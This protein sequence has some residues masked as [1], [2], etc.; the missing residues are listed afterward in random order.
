MNKNWRSRARKNIDKR[1]SEKSSEQD[2]QAAEVNEAQVVV[3]EP[4]MAHQN[5]AEALQPGKQSLHFPAAPIAAQRPPVLRLRLGPVLAVGSNPRNSLGAQLLIE[6]ITVVSAV[7]HK[8]LRALRSEP[9]RKCCCNQRRLMRGSPRHVHGE[10]NTCS[11]C[12]CHDLAAFPALGFPHCGPPFFAAAKVASTKHSDKSSFPRSRRSSAQA[13]SPSA[14]APLR[15]HCWKRSWQVDLGGKALGSS[16]HCAPVRSIHKMPSR[17]LRSS[18]R[19]RPRRSSRAWGWGS[20]DSTMAHW[21]SVNFIADKLNSQ[22][23]LCLDFS[24]EL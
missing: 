8:A 17:I 6:G 20:K 11:V 22:T 12:H 23:L 14:R 1:S 9:M 4:I 21:A 15:F 10:R 18:W 24:D 19:A 2:H 13:L 3:S 16:S 5:P 7:A